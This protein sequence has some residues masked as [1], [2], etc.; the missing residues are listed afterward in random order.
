LLQGGVEAGAAIWRYGSAADCSDTTS[1]P[2]T[3][4]TSVAVTANAK[5]IAHLASPIKLEDLADFAG[6]RQW[7]QSELAYGLL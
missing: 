6:M 7:V 2:I 3:D 1:K 5:V 4:L